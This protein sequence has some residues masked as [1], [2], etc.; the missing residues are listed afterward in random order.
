MGNCVRDRIALKT[1]TE[2]ESM[3][4]YILQNQSRF[5]NP[6]FDAKEN[7]ELNGGIIEQVPVTAQHSVKEWREVFF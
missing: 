3:W 2:T 6:F 4:T 5:T 7:E 1:Y